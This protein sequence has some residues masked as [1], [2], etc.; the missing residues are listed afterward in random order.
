MPPESSKQPPRATRST[1]TRPILSSAL[2]ALLEERPFEQL[3]VR[4]IT[5]KAEIGYATFFR[6]YPD[7]EALLNDVAAGQISELLS[8]T[9]PMLYTAETRASARTLCAYVWEHRKLWSTLLTGGAAGTLKDEFIRQA[10]RIAEA[11]PDPDAWLPA[12]LTVVFYVTGAVEILTWWLKQKHP[13]S[14]DEM[15]EVVDCLTVAPSMAH[16]TRRRP[17]LKSK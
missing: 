6:H 4:E 10:Q 11:R 1:Q 17:L 7:K 8:M 2:L 16:S 9:L 12:D 14:V 15:A 3:T 13:P 5:A